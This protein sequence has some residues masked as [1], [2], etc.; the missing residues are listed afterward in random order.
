MLLSLP[1]G[2]FDLVKTLNFQLFTE[3]EDGISI[4]DSSLP[5][6]EGVSDEKIKGYE[7]KMYYSNIA[8][9]QIEDVVQKIK[10]R[11]I[12]ALIEE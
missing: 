10:S 2:S 7:I 11:K 8:K 5:S 6:Y 1:E 3:G 9:E 4:F 12:V